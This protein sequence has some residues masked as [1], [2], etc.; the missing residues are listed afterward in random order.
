MKLHAPIFAILV[1]TAFGGRAS[2]A[3]DNPDVPDFV[4]AFEVQCAQYE[5]K[6]RTA[7][8]TNKITEAYGS[9]MTFLDRE[10]NKA[11]EGLLKHVSGDARETLVTSE[12]KWI[13]YRDSE[14]A[15]IIANWNVQNFGTSSAISRSDYRADIVKQRVVTLLHYLKNY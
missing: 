8:D 1:L 5:S 10:L 2:L 6:V 13:Q 14:D 7:S 3:I 4:G 9:Y 11:Y 15:F 12:R